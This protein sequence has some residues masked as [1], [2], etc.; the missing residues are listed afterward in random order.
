L[1]AQVQRVRSE[2]DGLRA[3]RVRLQAEH[4]DAS[5]HLAELDYLRNRVATIEAQLRTASGERDQARAE[6]TAAQ[7]EIATLKERLDQ[8]E[9]DPPAT[10][11]TTRNRRRGSR[12]R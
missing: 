6:L 1:A 2:Q 11:G 7:Q 4:R 5:Q 8:A 9:A 10:T 12:S 3:E